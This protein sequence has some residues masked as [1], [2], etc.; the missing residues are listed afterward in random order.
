MDHKN[1]ILAGMLGKLTTEAGFT[2]DQIEFAMRLS[3][4]LHIAL[5]DEQKAMFKECFI[6]KAKKVGRFTMI[7]HGLSRDDSSLLTQFLMDSNNE[8]VVSVLCNFIEAEAIDFFNPDHIKPLDLEHTSP[9]VRAHVEKLRHE[10]KV[11]KEVV[12]LKA[13]IA[14]LNREKD[15]NEDALHET[16]PV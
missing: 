3:Q 6:G 2:L 10:K 11:A 14:K 1:T 8:H 12:E 9:R 7:E 4:E 5:S 13:L 16:L 15:A